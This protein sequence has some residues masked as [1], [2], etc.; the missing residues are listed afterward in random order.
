[1]VHG[2]AL[3]YAEEFFRVREVANEFSYQLLDAAVYSSGQLEL[4]DQYFDIAIERA[5]TDCLEQMIRQ[6]KENLREPLTTQPAQGPNPQKGICR[7]CPQNRLDFQNGAGALNFRL[8]AT[9]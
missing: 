8:Q 9:R 3:E 2:T 7:L 4:G 1:M 5:P 6:Q